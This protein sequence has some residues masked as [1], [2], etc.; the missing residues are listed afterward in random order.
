[1][2]SY[3]A[4]AGISFHHT[5]FVSSLQPCIGVVKETAVKG[6]GSASMK[7]G[8]WQ[9]K[10]SN[11]EPS[12]YARLFLPFAGGRMLLGGRIATARAE[13]HATGE[14]S[15]IHR[16]RGSGLTQVEPTNCADIRAPASIMFV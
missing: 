7:V 3:R 6:G 13:R 11:F 16:L 1:M 14:C 8:S 15:D 2:S 4:S 10:T 9:I 5:F 12:S